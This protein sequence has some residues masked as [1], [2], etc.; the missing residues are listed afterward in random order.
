[1]VNRMGAGGRRNGPRNPWS[2][3]RQY[4]TSCRFLSRPRVAN[5]DQRSETDFFNSSPP[6]CQPAQFELLNDG[7]RLNELAV[8]AHWLA[9]PDAVF[10][11]GW[12]KDPGVTSD[13][14]GRP[15]AVELVCVAVVLAL[16]ADRA[17]RA[18]GGG[19][20]K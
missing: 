7:A 17:V 9:I 4:C 15:G 5:S 1:M 11:I 19:P 2:G 16:C 3:G 13:A 12:G 18:N 8:G 20:F 14:H 6:R 10:L